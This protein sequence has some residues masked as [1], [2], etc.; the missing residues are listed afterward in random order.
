MKAGKV[1]GDSTLD[2]DVSL[3]PLSVFIKLKLKK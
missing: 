1:V 3:C 2:E